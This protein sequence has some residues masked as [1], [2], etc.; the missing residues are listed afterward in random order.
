MI[1]LGRP[2]DRFR[3]WPVFM[4]ACLSASFLTYIIPEMVSVAMH[5]QTAGLHNFTFPLLMSVVA[6]PVIWLL[7][8]IAL[9]WTARGALVR[10]NRGLIAGALAGATYLA[11]AVALSF[12]T[13]VS[14][15][16]LAQLGLRLFLTPFVQAR[17]LALHRVV[18]WG[19]SDPPLGWSFVVAPLIGCV[20]G[21][22][23][24]GWLS[25]GDA[26]HRP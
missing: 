17:M 5:P 2:R 10:P 11:A 1:E 18:G 4:L 16:S 3:R 14:N 25:R 21:G 24:Y 7:L 26:G 19:L 15:T 8:A 13:P 23:L 6:G 22:W 12:S 20:F 9:A